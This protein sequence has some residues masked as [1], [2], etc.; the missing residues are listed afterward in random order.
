MANPLVTE[1]RIDE[2]V[3]K[4]VA[5]SLR[6][7]PSAV[8]PDA[9]IM[10]D[11]GGTSL[12]FLD[13]TFRLEQAFGVRLSHATIVDH[14]EEAFGEGKAIDAQGS[15][16]ADAVEILRSRFGAEGALQPGMYADEVPRLVTPATLAVGVREILSRLPATC[17]HCKAT[18]WESSNG[19]RVKCGACGKDAVYPDG[20]ALIRSWL[21]ETAKSRG[22]FAA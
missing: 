1:A 12:D 14:I 6:K 21:E 9:S 19:A 5:Q 16:T 3:R 15:L 18:K 4:A 20:D 22:L 17:T 8:R 7:D 13:M 2:E 10:T 11:L